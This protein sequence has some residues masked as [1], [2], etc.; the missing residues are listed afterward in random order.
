MG[1]A[2]QKGEFPPAPGAASLAAHSGCLGR[3]LSCLTSQDP[4]KAFT[5]SPHFQENLCFLTPECCPAG[6]NYGSGLWWAGLWIQTSDPEK[7]LES[8]L[9]TSPG[10]WDK[11]L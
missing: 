4:G 7:I 11:G 9:T 5:G 8:E 6:G 2:C 10:P 3:L 1:A